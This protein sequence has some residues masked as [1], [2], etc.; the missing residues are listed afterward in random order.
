MPD[1]FDNEHIDNMSMS[2]DEINEL[3]NEVIEMPEMEHI[4][5]RSYND[6]MLT[7]GIAGAH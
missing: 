2:I 4:A 7:A 3:F 5:Y 6:C 1:N